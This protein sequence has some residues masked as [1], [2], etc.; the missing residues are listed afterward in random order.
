M[1]ERVIWFAYYKEDPIA[2]FIN[3]PDVNQYFKHFNGQLG[4]LQKIHLL[5]M[6]WR[7]NKYKTDRFS[8]WRSA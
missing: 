4:L 2:M 3:I 8:I 7:K 1:D 5:W 6:K